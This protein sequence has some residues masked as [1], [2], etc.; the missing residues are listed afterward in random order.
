[1]GR[2]GL[3]GRA[4]TTVSRRGGR[5]RSR[6]CGRD[7]HYTPGPI[8]LLLLLIY[9]LLLDIDLLL[10]RKLMSLNGLLLLDELKMSLWVSLGL[11][12]LADRLIRLVL[13][14]H[15]LNDRVLARVHSHLAARR[16]RIRVIKYERELVLFGHE[17]L[18]GVEFEKQVGEDVLV[19]V[20]L[21]LLDGV[22]GGCGV[23]N[24]VYEGLEKRLLAAGC[25][26]FRHLMRL[27]RQIE[28]H[29]LLRARFHLLLL[30]IRDELWLLDL[31][32]DLLWLLRILLLLLRLLRVLA[33]RLLVIGGRAGLRGAHVVRRGCS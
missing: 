20:L 7:P 9:L 5:G 30:L 16:R 28:R 15:E 22:G 17:E 1:M 8:K 3:G 19:Y 18:S 13:G 21:L 24:R 10:L 29:L 6:D 33:G 32:L 25:L 31:E 4:T 27:P 2:R 12:E 23:G 26:V 14:L 11:N